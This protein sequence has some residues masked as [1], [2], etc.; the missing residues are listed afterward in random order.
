MPP[1]AVTSHRQTITGSFDPRPAAADPE[2]LRRQ[3][4]P[5][6][7]ALTHVSVTVSNLPAG[8]AWYRRL[9]GAEPVLDEDTGPFHQSRMRQRIKG[10]V[11]LSLLTGLFAAGCGGG[12][13]LP[14]QADAMPPPELVSYVRQGGSHGGQDRLYVTPDGM[15]SVFTSFGTR[16]T[17]RLPAAE[18]AELR[19]M[20]E[21]VGFADLPKATGSPDPDGVEYTLRYTG[22]H[23]V[24]GGERGLPPVL[25]PVVAALAGLVRRQCQSELLVSY[26]RRKGDFDGQPEHV[27]VTL[28]G[29]C[30][31][32][33]PGGVSANGRL[34]ATE[35]AALRRVLESTRFADLPTT[36]P[37]PDRDAF[38]HWVQFADHE[39]LA[40]DATL[41]ATLAP[42]IA[43]FDGLIQRLCGQLLVSYERRVD[44]RVIDRLTIQA[45]G[46]TYYRG[47]SRA[48]TST[49]SPAELT[50]LHRVLEAAGFADIPEKNPPPATAAVVHEVEH[51]VWY[52]NRQVSAV[53]RTMPPAL[54]PVT[55]ALD[56]IVGRH[57]RS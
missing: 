8:V 4:M 54:K 30:I 56:Q 35:V 22:R 40:T 41:P 28:D 52:A 50:D 23:V 38:V 48:K 9:S 3:H 7:P 49:L 39:V 19:R 11:L 2:K 12:L 5:A 21:S 25:K 6:F 42:V 13:D 31:L 45:N 43:T 46:S 14:S 29:G 53:N 10:V 36:N 16:Q 15:C 47:N 27:I 55:A 20:L 51:S 17:G 57:G 44:N 26:A 34:P 18:L 1:L 32:T 33:R 24:R 37:S